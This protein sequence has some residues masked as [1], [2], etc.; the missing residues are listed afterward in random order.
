L[1]REYL[2]EVK[3]GKIEGL[4]VGQKFDQWEWIG[5]GKL[6]HQGLEKLANAAESVDVPHNLICQEPSVRLCYQCRLPPI[7]ELEKIASTFSIFLQKR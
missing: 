6:I 5:S 4:V 7:A 2:A 3:F 1:T